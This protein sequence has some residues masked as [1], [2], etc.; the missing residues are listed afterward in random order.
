M[1]YASCLATTNTWHR[2]RSLPA[3]APD[4]FSH[5]AFKF[6]VW[7]FRLY[8]NGLWGQPEW[9]GNI[10]W[11]S[12]LNLLELSLGDHSDFVNNLVHAKNFVLNQL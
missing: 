7:K 3:R 9:R 4:Q 6:I 5:I 12:N 8:I 2:C 1:P 10:K 11:L